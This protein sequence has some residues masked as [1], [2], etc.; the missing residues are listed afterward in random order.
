MG[1]KYPFLKPLKPGQFEAFTLEEKAQYLGIPVERLGHEDDF[2]CPVCGGTHFGRFGQNIELVSC[3]DEFQINC[4][5]R[6]KPWGSQD[7]IPN[8][9]ARR[10]AQNLYE[11]RVDEMRRARLLYRYEMPD[12]TLPVPEDKKADAEMQLKKRISDLKGMIE[13]TEAM[14]VV[15]RGTTYTVANIP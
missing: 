8:P 9:D 2:Y 1:R 10:W 7:K 4:Y 11:V 14:I 3:H 12:I 6:S 13:E 15:V 5:W